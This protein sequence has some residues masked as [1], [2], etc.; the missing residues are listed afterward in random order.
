MVILETTFGIFA[1]P[2]DNYIFVMY[3]TYLYH[4]N[5]CFI[6]LIFLCFDLTGQ[7][8]D[9]Q[10]FEQNGKIGLKNE[11]GSV[12]LPPSFEA[13]GWS[14][15]SFSVAG[16]ITGYKLNGYWGLINLNKQYITKAEFENLIYTGADRVVAIK[17]TS[18]ISRKAGSL[19]LE[20]EVTIPFVYDAINLYGMRA[21]VMNKIGNTYR[22]GLVDLANRSILPVVYNNIYQVGPL[23]FAVENQDGKLA[24]FSDEGK[25]ITEF[26]IDSISSFHRSHAII[27]SKGWQGVMNSEGILKVDP[28]FS[29]IELQKDGG[30]RGLQPQTWK[31]LDEKN[32]EINSIQADELHAFASDYFIVSRSGKSGLIN[33]E[34]QSV[35]PIMYDHIGPISNGLMAVEKNKKWALID[36]QQKEILPFDFDSLSWD[37]TIALGLNKGMGKNQWTFLNQETNTRSSKKYEAIEKVNGGYFKSKKNGYFGLLSHDGKEVVHCVYDSILEV[38]GSLAS[39]WFRG[40]FGI[41]STSEEWKLV[42]QQFHVRLVNE[43]RYLE[44]QGKN[45]FL[46]SFEGNILYFTSYPIQVMDGYLMESLPNGADRKIGF[47]GLEI[48]R[49]NFPTSKAVVNGMRAIPKM[50]AKD[51]PPLIMMQRQGKFGFVDDRGRLIIPNRYDS[52]KPFSGKLAAFKLIGK[53]GYLNATDKIIINPLFDFAGDFQGGYA[54]ASK[55]KKFGVVDEHGNIQLSFRYDS[56]RTSKEKLL[57]YLSGKVGVASLQGKILV[58]A[59][60]DHIEQLTNGHLIIGNDNKFGLISADGLNLIPLMYSFLEYD[61]AKNLYLAHLKAEWVM[62]KVD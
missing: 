37:G 41:I 54:I 7:A 58:E 51:S 36:F 60:Y 18:N 11:Q 25:A 23:R 45:V 19:T 57:T 16:Q 26:F 31:I 20:G 30:I 1:H 55:N 47:D 33:K 22:F 8:A 40:L 32:K 2:R 6:I 62:V 59:R 10:L 29:A 61:E 24:L 4:V 38:K 17:K 43:Q 28:K 48:R 52:M 3:P 21:V 53:W 49:V 44:Q 34:L 27:Y 15:G 42:P 5:K 39:V 56:I 46:K 14:D 9:F 35:W 13:L 12:V 50:E